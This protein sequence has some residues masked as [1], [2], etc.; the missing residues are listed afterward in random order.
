MRRNREIGLWRGEG[1]RE[2]ESEKEE[3]MKTARHKVK[4]GK[5]ETFRSSSMCQ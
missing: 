5:K 1:E 2:R 4:R 3:K